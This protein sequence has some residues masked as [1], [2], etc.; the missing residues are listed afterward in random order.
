LFLTQKTIDI[1]ERREE[2]GEET[3]KQRFEETVRL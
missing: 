1:K 2:T 3:G